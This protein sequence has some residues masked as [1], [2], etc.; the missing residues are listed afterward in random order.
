M[1]EAAQW[2]DNCFATLTYDDE[3]LPTFNATAYGG[4]D[5]LATLAPV[6]TQLWLKRLRKALAPSR[7]RFFLVGEYGEESWRPHYHVA[8]FNVPS[9]R[10]GSTGFGMVKPSWARCCASCQVVGET[11]GKG[12]VLLGSLEASSAQYICGYVTKKMTRRDDYRLL[13]REPEFSRQSNQNGGLGKSAMWE[14]ASQL[15][16]FNLDQTQGD[17][18]VALRHGSRSLPLGRYL[19]REL[20]S[21]IG[22]EKNAPESTLEE[23]KEEMRPLREA[24]F[25]ASEPLKAHYQESV[26]GKVLNFKSRSRIFKGKRHL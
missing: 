11:W 15:M 8:L 13:G 7:F 22:K 2:S 21:M 16:A 4:P 12:N 18:P 14:V 5:V 1:L 6:D 10:R 3:H 17:V 23:I 24:A 20:R 26:Q 9:C 19:R 25:E